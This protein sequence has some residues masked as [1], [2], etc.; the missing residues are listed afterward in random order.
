MNK[1]IKIADFLVP[2]IFGCHR[3]EQWV[4]YIKIF[5]SIITY[6]IIRWQIQPAFTLIL[7]NLTSFIMKICQNYLVFIT[8]KF[9]KR[10]WILLCR[11]KRTSLFFWLIV[12]QRLQRDGEPSQRR[13]PRRTEQNKN[14]D[15]RRTTK[16]TWPQDKLNK[17]KQRQTGH[18]PVFAVHVMHKKTF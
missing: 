15:I 8:S 16:A 1:K 6:L 14:K 7:T 12:S 9:L 18:L 17:G 3:K 13:E 5:F 4:L 2:R 10:M 11:P